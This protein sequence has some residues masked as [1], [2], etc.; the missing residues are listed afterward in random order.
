[1]CRGMVS[2]RCVT[3]H[4][5]DVCINRLA[6][7]EVAF[8]DFSVMDMA[9][10]ASVSAVVDFNQAAAVFTFEAASIADLPTA[11][12]IERGLILQY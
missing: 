3:L 12:C 11:L 8:D 7:V 10:Q 6:N 2:S 5:V 4:F 1:M 9:F